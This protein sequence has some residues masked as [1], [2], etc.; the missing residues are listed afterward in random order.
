MYLKSRSNQN[1]INK[2]L[3]KIQKADVL[4]IISCKYSLL[5]Y[6]QKIVILFLFVDDL[7]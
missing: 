5:F 7:I 3:I 1:K 4:L 2:K 6:L